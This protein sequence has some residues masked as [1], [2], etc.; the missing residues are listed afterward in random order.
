M[1]RARKFR[2]FILNSIRFTSALL[3]AS[4]LPRIETTPFA[5]LMSWKNAQREARDWLDSLHLQNVKGRL[6]DLRES[7]RSLR[8]RG[9]FRLMVLRAAKRIIADRGATAL[10]PEGENFEA[11]LSSVEST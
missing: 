6:V 8:Y 9:H 10:L 5:N 7:A 3:V 4:M 2:A 11:E 1:E